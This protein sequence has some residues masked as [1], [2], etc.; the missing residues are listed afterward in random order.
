L[1]TLWRNDTDAVAEAFSTKS[2]LRKVF[3]NQSDLTDA[4]FRR[5]PLQQLEELGIDE[6]HV[7]AQA[8]D[9]LHKC[10]RLEVLALNPTQLTES[11]VETL[12]SLPELSSLSKYSARPTPAGGDA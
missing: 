6:T 7:T 12:A 11:V 2:T 8:L 9:E 5:L 1:G 3:L 10:S 4:G